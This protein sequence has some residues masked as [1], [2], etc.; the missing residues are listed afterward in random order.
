MAR[1]SIETARAQSDVF[2]K[3][4]RDLRITGTQQ[5]ISHGSRPNARVLYASHRLSRW[6]QRWRCVCGGVSPCRGCK[7]FLYLSSTAPFI[8]SFVFVCAARAGGTIPRRKTTIMALRNPNPPRAK[9]RQKA[10]KGGLTLVINL[11]RRRDRLR[12]IRGV[13]RGAVSSWERIDAV[14]GKSLTWAE[15]SK[16]LRSKALANAQWAEARDVPTICSKTGSFSPHLTLGAVGCALSHR[17]AWERLASSDRDWALILEDDVTRVAEELEA[18]LERC[19][20]SLP[21][22][23]QLCLVGFHESTGQLLPR[24]QRLRLSELGPD[25]GQT[26]LFGYLLRRSAASELLSAHGQVFP[27]RIR[28][29]SS[30][31][32]ATGGRCR[33]LPSRPKRCSSTRPSRRR[34]RVTRMCRR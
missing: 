13:L 26:G 7:G 17:K 6:A 10:A 5:A 32:R 31:A 11:A 23:W 16:H 28:W 24:G 21:S 22:S 3:L 20:A 27:S 19:V 1:P 15:A 8:S 34:R 25:E 4:A 9:Q 29:T 2:C 18:T 33:A 12:T 30:W 14:D